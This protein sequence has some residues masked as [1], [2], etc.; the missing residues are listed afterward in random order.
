MTAWRQSSPHDLG[1]FLTESAV[2][3]VSEPMHRRL[4]AEMVMIDLW[5]RWRLAVPDRREDAPGRH[6]PWVPVPVRPLQLEPGARAGRAAVRGPG[7]RKSAAAIQLA[8]HRRW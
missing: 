8:W 6:L 3:D 1:Q 7:F 4:L 2:G 5:H